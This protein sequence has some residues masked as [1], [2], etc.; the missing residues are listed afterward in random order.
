MPETT[1]IDRRLAVAPM[2][3]WTDRHARFFLRQITRH[4]LL[5]TEMITAAAILRG[6]REHLLG[7]DPGEHPVA[8]QLGGADA[9]QLAAAAAIG[10]AW[11]YDEIN[12]NV[13]CPSLRVQ[14]AR[15]GACLMAEPETVARAVEA[16]RRAV[17]VPVTI[18]SRIGIDGRE[19]YDELLHF[20][21]CVA[22]AG[23]R[24]FIVHARIAILS[25]LTPKDNREIP[26]LQYDVV[27]RLKAERP[28][29]TIVLNGGVTDLETARRTLDQLDGVMIGRAAYQ[30][31]YTLLDADRLIFGAVGHPLSRHD[32]ARA[33]IPYIEAARRRGVPF[34][35]VARHMLGLFNGLP[36]SRAFRR[37]VSENGPRPGAGPEVLAQAIALVPEQDAGVEAG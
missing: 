22:A 36:G 13:G 27:H 23:C 18:K 17:Q 15:F 31:P 33:M 25:G 12:L 6:S 26:P 24:V 14:S 11:G 7:F 19:T 21:D 1:P 9:Q 8:L 5:Y 20:I 3:D 29:L 37:F 32:V 34:Y 10:A 16:M 30:D 28:H 35:T 4:T 2:M